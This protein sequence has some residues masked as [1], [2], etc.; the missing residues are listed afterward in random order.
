[1]DSEDRKDTAALA[2]SLNIEVTPE[3]EQYINTIN[4]CSKFKKNIEMNTEYGEG[5]FT[6]CSAH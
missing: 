5:C 3:K 1:L 6:Y 4:I 2:M